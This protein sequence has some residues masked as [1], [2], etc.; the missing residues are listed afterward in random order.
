MDKKNDNNVIE[1]KLPNTPRRNKVRELRILLKEKERRRLERE[2]LE[3]MRK[4][5]APKVKWSTV[6]LLGLSFGSLLSVILLS[7][8]AALN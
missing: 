4:Q 5:W 2:R 3:A 8:Y 1:F 6:I 7:V